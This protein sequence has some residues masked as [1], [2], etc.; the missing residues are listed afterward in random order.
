MKDPEKFLTALVG[1]PDQV[2]VMQEQG[3]VIPL[4][5]NANGDW[6]ATASWQGGEV[7]RDVTHYSPVLVKGVGGGRGCDRK[8]A[9]VQMVLAL[10]ADDVRA[11]ES[12]WGLPE[13]SRIWT[14][15]SR[16]AEGKVRAKPESFQ[17]VYSLSQPV[18]R[19]GGDVSGAELA[20]ALRWAVDGHTG[21][22]S[23]NNPERWARVPGV[24]MVPKG[25]PAAA[26]L[27][28]LD[29]YEVEPLDLLLTLAGR[30]DSDDL[31]RVCGMAL[32][33]T[34]E[35]P[36]SRDALRKVDPVFD[37]MVENGWVTGGRK[38]DAWMVECPHWTEHSPEPDGSI[39]K[40]MNY[41]PAFGAF[42]CHRGKPEN[43]SDGH[44]HHKAREKGYGSQTRLVRLMIERLGGPTLSGEE[45][46]LLEAGPL[47]SPIAMTPVKLRSYFR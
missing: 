32:N 6:S 37:W 38:G 44:L 27:V 46:K 17:V 4:A 42:C 45:P 23:G 34:R 15:P 8:A 13:F 35:V 20:S 1:G 24:L 9:A 30:L 2:R 5:C 40:G 7:R 3:W 16:P 22:P 12:L 10:I 14:G 21:D 25:K 11:G 19:N 47:S 41:L 18:L 43:S 33:V 28:H 36:A 26:R 31:E 29:G 39:N